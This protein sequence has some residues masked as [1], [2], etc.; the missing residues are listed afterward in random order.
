MAS[1]QPSTENISQ[2]VLLMNRRRGLRLTLISLS[3]FTSLALPFWAIMASSSVPAS[4]QYCMSTTVIGSIFG[5]TLGT[6]LIYLWINACLARK[7][8][9]AP[10][11]KKAGSARCLVHSRALQ[12]VRDMKAVCEIKDQFTLADVLPSSL[13]CSERD[14]ASVHSNASRN[15]SHHSE[16]IKQLR[17]LDD[18]TVNDEQVME[19]IDE[20]AAN[21]GPS[22]VDQ[23]HPPIDM[24]NITS[25]RIFNKQPSY[26]ANSN[27]ANEESQKQLLASMLKDSML[28]FDNSRNDVVPQRT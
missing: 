10:T 5:A 16:N 7:V 3:I 9:Y 17:P 20:P 11:Q 19:A 23:A 15:L 6:N 24:N 12:I 28:D 25:T 14:V 4:S 22:I 18:R 13:E 8:A 2:P 26:D 1:Q 27:N 21:E